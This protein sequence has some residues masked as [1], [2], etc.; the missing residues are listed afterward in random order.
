MRSERSRLAVV[1]AVIVPVGF[2]VKFAVPGSLG[3]WCCLYGGAI[4]Y[5][6]FWILFLRLLVPR[7][8]PLHC[9]ITVFLLTC[10]LETLQL[11]HPPFLEHIRTTFLGAVLLGTSFDP[12]DF[13]Y[14][15]LGCGAGILVLLAVRFRSGLEADSNTE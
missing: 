11:W 13:L 3:R 5:E 2:F 8:R 6:I 1:L 14:Y 10:L 15:I 4:L 9:G 7:L 12:R